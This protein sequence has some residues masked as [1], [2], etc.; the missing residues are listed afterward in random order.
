L[1]DGRVDSFLTMFPTGVTLKRALPASRF[2]S[3]CLSAKDALDRCSCR[4][5][6]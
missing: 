5:T 2:G 1:Q 4:R 6:K 3:E